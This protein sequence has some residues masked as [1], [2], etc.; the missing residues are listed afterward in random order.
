MPRDPLARRV[1]KADDYYWKDLKV[2]IGIF[3]E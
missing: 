2:Y 3:Y 1:K